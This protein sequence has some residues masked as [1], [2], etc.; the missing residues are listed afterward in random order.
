M[1]IVLDGSPHGVARL[2]RSLNMRNM[3]VGV[4]GQ[5]VTVRS[6]FPVGD[7]VSRFQS[8]AWAG[9]AKIVAVIDHSAAARQ[10]GLE[11]RST[12]V[13]IFGNPAVGTHV[14]EVAPLVALEL[15][16]KVLVWDDDGRTLITYADPISVADRYGLAGEGRSVF[17]RIGPLVQSVI[18]GDSASQ[19]SSC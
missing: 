6:P 18:N 8:L 17:E 2:A 3:K 14:M 12:T 4:A 15:P 1:T 19:L 9:R 5:I 11:L 13:I 7:T 10:V 16:L